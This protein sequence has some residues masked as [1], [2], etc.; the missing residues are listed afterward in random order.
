MMKE[1]VF[2]FDERLSWWVEKVFLR[3]MFV[4]FWPFLSWLTWKMCHGQMP[5]ETTF[6]ALLQGSLSCWIWFT[7]FLKQPLRNWRKATLCSLDP[8][9]GWPRNAEFLLWLFLPREGR[10]AAIGDT[11]EKFEMM[12]ECFGRSR[13]VSVASCVL[14]W[15]APLE[16]E[17]VW[18]GCRVVAPSHL[19]PVVTYE[20]FSCLRRE[21]QQWGESA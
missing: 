19:A 15:R 1:R 14:P 18:L 13:A 7:L 4:G 17:F 5:T 6:S 16:V 9:S 12:F 11:N 20:P 8:D 3:I 21:R 10:E 2:W